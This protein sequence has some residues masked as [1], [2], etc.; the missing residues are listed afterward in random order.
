MVENGL[1]RVVYYYGVM[2]MLSSVDH[3]RR[4]L[5]LAQGR[6]IYGPLC[7]ARGHESVGEDSRSV[8]IKKTP[9]SIRVS[10]HVHVICICIS[11]GVLAKVFN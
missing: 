9:N 8:W 3:C 5:M 1:R 4:S 10:V 7:K 6:N 11:I 2:G